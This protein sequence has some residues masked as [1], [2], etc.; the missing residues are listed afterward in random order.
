MTVMF[1]QYDIYKIPSLHCGYLIYSIKYRFL[2]GG[3][4]KYRGFIQFVLVIFIVVA[5]FNYRR[6]TLDGLAIKTGMFL[7]GFSSTKSASIANA[8]QPV[9]N[10][11]ENLDATKVIS[12]EKNV[13]PEKEVSAEENIPLKITPTSDSFM[14]NFFANIFNK[15]LETPNGQIVV[16]E[17]LN[18]AASQHNNQHAQDLEERKYLATNI[19]IGGGKTVK[20]GDEI[21]ITYAIYNKFDMNKDKKFFKAKIVVGHNNLAKP[22]E[23]AIIGMKEGGQRKVA[24]FIED[25]IYVANQKNDKPQY[26]QYVSEVTLE[27]VHG[28]SLDEKNS[29]RVFVHNPSRAGKRVACGDK[30]HFTYTVSDMHNK[31]LTVKN[32]LNRVS[33]GVNSDAKNPLRNIYNS[34][35][36]THKDHVRVTVILQYKQVKELI[37]DI[38]IN[39]NISDND[40][41]VLDLSGFP[42]ASLEDLRANALFNKDIASGSLTQ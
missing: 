24:Y 30:V 4:M 14:A 20:C 40:M 8:K 37:P 34:I 29:V 39:K 10:N 41:V 27:K 33:L 19:K 9:D 16:R 6:D 13:A 35:V 28:L 25:P 3:K 5:V 17:V 38:K 22:L 21:E 11:Q 26:V 15:V 23:N 36:D 2:E 18:K 12:E 7:R 42:S 31:P 32:A 1:L